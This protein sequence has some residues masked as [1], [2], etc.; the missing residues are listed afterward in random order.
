MSLTGSLK[1]PF[2]EG[3]ARFVGVFDVPTQLVHG[4]AQILLTLLSGHN[5]HVAFRLMR[6]RRKREHLK[7]F[8]MGR[9]MR[10]WWTTNDE[11][12]MEGRR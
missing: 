9:P 6:G 12:D 7:A 4:S 8:G 5:L 1:S 11:V 2:G 10:E 3:Q